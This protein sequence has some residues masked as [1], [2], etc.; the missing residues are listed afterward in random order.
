MPI[1]YR[2][3]DVRPNQLPNLLPLSPA[4]AETVAMSVVE[5]AR[6]A[7]LLRSQSPYILLGPKDRHLPRLDDGVAWLRAQGFPVFFRLGGGSAV[8]LDGQCVSFA[9]IRPCRD[10][11]SWR[12]NFYDLT[13][14]VVRG[15][16]RLDIAAEFGEAEGSYCPGMY[17]LVVDGRKVAGIA[18]AIRRG[19][20][21][22]SGM[23]LVHQ[24]PVRTTAVI[25]EFYERAGSDRQFRATAVTRLDALRPLSMDSVFD[26]IIAGYSELWDLQPSELTSTEAALAGRLYEERLL[27]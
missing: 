3:V 13:E 23:L 11:T 18:Q 8:L 25:Q 5:S 12:K 24:D 16:K 27:A 2:L 14:G 21:M 20:A 15:L 17:D 6:P 10:L 19:Y 1:T 22:V 9:V 4:L 7:L 26:A